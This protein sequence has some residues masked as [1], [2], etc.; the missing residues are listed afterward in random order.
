[1][2]A[3]VP[4]TSQ[5]LG[6]SDCGHNNYRPGR[7]LDPFAG[8]GTTLAVADIHDRDGIGFDIDAR[9]SGLVAA[10]S[11]EVKR[12]LYGTTPEIPGQLSAF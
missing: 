8:T 4:H 10:R 1:M 11:E 12:A 7:V 9:N 6:W 5:T 3:D 2:V